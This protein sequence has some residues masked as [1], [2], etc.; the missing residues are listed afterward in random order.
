MIPIV[1]FCQE[2][3]EQIKGQFAATCIECVSKRVEATPSASHNTGS[4]KLPPFNE[5]VKVF[6]NE[7]GCESDPRDSRLLSRFYDCIQRQLRAVA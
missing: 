5:C 3:G 4:P 6:F 1:M 2:C 7:P